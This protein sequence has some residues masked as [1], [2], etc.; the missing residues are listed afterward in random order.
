METYPIDPDELKKGDLVSEAVIRRAYGK[1]PGTD[2]YRFAQMKLR[3]FI[4][5]RRTDLVT[6]AEGF[7]VRVLTDEEAAPYSDT[8]FHA[9]RRGM[10]N[11]WRRQLR[12]D[13]AQL[14]QTT[15]NT[16]ARALS[17]N[18]LILQSVEQTMK[19]LR[20]SER[21]PLPKLT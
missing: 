15:A 16:H 7:A 19:Q 14:D 12:V 13:A 8:R 11:S 6:K 21:E 20:T 4:E 17:R 10:E 1:T 18:G 3:E 2:E 5:E 9:S